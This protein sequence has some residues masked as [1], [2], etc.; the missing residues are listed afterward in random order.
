M[1]RVGMIAKSTVGGVVGMRSIRPQGGV[2]VSKIF[3]ITDST[4][5]DV[6]GYRIYY[7]ETGITVTTSSPYVDINQKG[8]IHIKDISSPPFVIDQAYDLVI[9][10]FN[11]DNDFTNWEDGTIR[12]NVQLRFWI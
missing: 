3:R 2:L 4:I 7:E 1:S 12:N 11:G 6:I 10:A 5:T 9:L 8:D